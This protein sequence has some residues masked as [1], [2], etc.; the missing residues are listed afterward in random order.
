MTLK[1]LSR[2]VLRVPIFSCVCVCV[3]QYGNPSN[4]LAHYDGTAEEL[5]A[6][7]DGKIDY[8]I[9][10][11]GTGGT[12]SGIAKKLKEKIPSIQVRLSRHVSRI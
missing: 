3:G 2:S 9:A 5:L 4:P 6:Q 10:T 11:A 12:I 8:L 7:C 1:L